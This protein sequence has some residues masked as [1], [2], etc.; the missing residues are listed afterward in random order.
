[1]G[2]PLV[3][4]VA[5]QPDQASR[6]LDELLRKDYTVVGV[7]T[8]FIPAKWPETLKNAR[9]GNLMLWRVGLTAA[10]P[11]GR[12]ALDRLASVHVGGQNL[13][14]FRNEEFDALYSRMQVLPDGPERL[15]L[16]HQ[17]KRISVAYAPYKFSVHRIVTDLTY[18]WVQGYRRPPY[19]NHWWQYVDVD[20]SLRDEAMQ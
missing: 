9:A 4:A 13:A 6:R 3:I 16:F 7:R 12:P 1:D 2:S 19:W 11:D 18:P 8:S 14:R 5:T 17:A 10:A 15:E 20:E